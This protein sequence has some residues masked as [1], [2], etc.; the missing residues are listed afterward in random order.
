LALIEPG[1]NGLI[2]NVKK[3]RDEHY[4]KAFGENLRRLRLRP[5]KIRTIELIN[6]NS[7]QN[8]EFQGEGL[9][10]I[11][12]VPQKSKLT[13]NTKE[14]ELEQ[15]FRTSLK[16]SFLIAVGDDIAFTINNK[17]SSNLQL[18]VFHN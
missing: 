17:T 14:S 5:F 11:I 15:T 7:S 1:P 3:F 18:L 12:Y 4:L 6:V 13:L 2:Y 8:L 16:N 9:L 10:K